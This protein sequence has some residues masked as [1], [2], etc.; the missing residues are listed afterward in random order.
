MPAPTNRRL[1][2]AQ[3]RLR[4]RFYDAEL[5]AFEPVRRQAIACLQLQPGDTVL[6]IGCGTGL[7]FDR[8]QQGVGSEGC[9]VGIEQSPEMAEIALQRV[10]QHAWHH[11]ILVNAPVERAAIPV[12]ADA[13][14]FHFTHDILQH[15]DEIRR[16]VGHL[17]PGA[18]VVAAG[19]QW[20]SPWDWPTNW[21]VLMAALYSTTSLAGLGQP[22]RHLAEQVGALQ[23]MPSPLSGVYIVSGIYVPKESEV[24]HRV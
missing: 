12:R 17:K 7:S 11:V 6:D 16:V 3:Y 2:L 8:L 13:A 18:R 5:A 1:A 15:S 10:A 24:S 22:W 9:V 19:L 20:S 4:A 21:L 23:A 14:L